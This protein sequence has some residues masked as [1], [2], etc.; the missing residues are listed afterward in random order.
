LTKDGKAYGVVT[1]DG[2]KYLANKAVICSVT[3]TQLYQRLL[4]AADVPAAI[5]KQAH[6]FQYG[7]ADMQIHLA[8]D[9][10]AEWLRSELADVALLHL[11]PDMDGV[12]RAI[13]AAECGLLPETATIVVGQPARLDPSRVPAGKGLLWIQLQELPAV[14][15]GDAAGEIDIPAD[16]KW[17]PP[18][19]E[20][21]ADRIIERIARHVPNLKQNIRQR[22]VLSPADLEAININLVG[23]DPYAG[24]CTMDQFF[25]W[26]PLRGVTNHNTPLKNLYHIGASTH[27][28]PGLGGGS[29]FLVAQSLA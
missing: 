23:G 25:L 3:P 14:I 1:T 9:E 10:P 11:T 13:N 28:G 21:Y 7:K 22:V 18:V 12:A 5:A 17:T 19:R 27:P 26:R 2:S 6:A 24:V 29:G 16:G 4:P 20:A 15:K 8:L